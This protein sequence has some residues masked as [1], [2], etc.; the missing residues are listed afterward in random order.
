MSELYLFGVTFFALGLMAFL[1]VGLCVAIFAL[2]T[3]AVNHHGESAQSWGG[4]PRW[5]D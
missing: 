3:S 1:A 5:L 2:A 4:R